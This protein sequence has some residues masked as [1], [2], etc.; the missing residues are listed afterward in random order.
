MV[1]QLKIYSDVSV[2]ISEIFS[3]IKIESAV[4]LGIFVIGL[5]IGIVFYTLVSAFGPNAKNLRDPFEEHE[6]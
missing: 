2:F 3:Y 1:G 4:V 6:D 5:F